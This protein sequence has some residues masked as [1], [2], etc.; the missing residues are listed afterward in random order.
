MN[1]IYAF[2]LSAWILSDMACLG[3]APL[4]RE[5]VRNADALSLL[6]L[7]DFLIDF[8]DKGSSSGFDHT[9]GCTFLYSAGAFFFR[10]ASN[11][12][13]SC[14]FRSSLSFFL[15]INHHKFEL[16]QTQSSHLYIK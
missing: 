8:N 11:W 4:L 6:C 10:A 7:I 12:L 9:I 1:R 5:L 2:A 3:D 16:P 15:I 14:C 13:R